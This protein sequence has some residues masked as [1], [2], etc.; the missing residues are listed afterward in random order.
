[1]RM[2]T[3]KVVLVVLVA[4]TVAVLVGKFFLMNLHDLHLISSVHADP[5]LAN[6]NLQ[7]SH[8]RPP[9]TGLLED[10]GG[11]QLQPEPPSADN[12]QSVLSKIQYWSKHSTKPVLTGN[13]PRKYLLFVRDCGGFNNLRMAFDI[14][15]AIAW[16]TGRTLV[17]PPPEGWYLIDWGPFSRMKPGPGADRSNSRVVG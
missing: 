5:V 17:L 9:Q 4:F 6:R 1:M 11:P 14:F 7:K 12:L 10:E 16:L 13:E 8:T 15:V 3:S 2:R